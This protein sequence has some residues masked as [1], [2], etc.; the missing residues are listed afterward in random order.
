MLIEKVSIEGFRNFSSANI[1]FA[2]NTLVIGG[3]NSGKT[4]LIAAL[5]LLLDKS[6]S[7]SDI[8]PSESDFHIPTTGLQANKFSITIFFSDIKEDAVLTILKG[9]VSNEGKCALRFCANRTDLSYQLMLGEDEDQLEEIPS[10]YYLKYINLRYVRSQRDLEKY[11]NTEK[12]QLLKISQ[13]NREETEVISDQ[14]QMGRIGRSLEIINERVRRLNYVKGATDSVNLELQKLAHDFTGYAVQLDSGAIQ[15]QQFIDNL[16]LGASTAGSKVMLGGDG[17][18][19]QILMALWKAKS[20][21]EFDPAHE[22]VFY[23][24][25]EPEA[26]LHPHQQRK[27]ADYLIN[28]LPGQTIITTHSPQIAA[29]YKP[30]SILHIKFNNGSSQAASGGCGDCISKAWDNLGY[31]MSI[32]P[33]EAFFAKCVLLVEGPSEVLFYSELSKR[34]DIDL[35]FYNISILAVD[36]VQFDVYIKILNAMEIPWVVRTDNDVS[37]I[38]KDK[39]LQRNL[40]GVNRCLGLAGIAKMPHAPVGTT[41][42]M[43]VDTGVWEAVSKQINEAGIFLSRI[44]LEHDLAHELPVEILACYES[45]DIETAIRYLQAKKAIRMRGFLG[46]YSD[47]LD[48]LINGELVKPLLHCLLRVGVAA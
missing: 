42:Q 24:I 18:N 30:D 3:N 31:R 4:N 47:S 11:I 33:A 14:K 20:Q 43:L 40:A 19:N 26:H 10:R 35:D 39:I 8:E 36:G 6:L 9:N 45:T 12:R 29:R 32:L 13:D 25:E 38:T 1:R 2:Q 37:D 27:L 15:V 23:C 17:R 28:D 7:E 22:A 41:P 34:L 21:R 5:R 16:K 46:K 48:D 44:D